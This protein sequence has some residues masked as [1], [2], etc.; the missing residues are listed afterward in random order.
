[1]RLM[2]SWQQGSSLADPRQFGLV[3]NGLS[4]A[5]DAT[6][7]ER[8]LLTDIERTPKA[9]QRLLGRISRPRE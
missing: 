2:P 1:M 7:S 9:R 3:L 5:S 8:E 4:T 6:R